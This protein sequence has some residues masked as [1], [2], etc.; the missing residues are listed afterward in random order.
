MSGILPVQV[1]LIFVIVCILFSY[2]LG[3]YFGML[4]EKELEKDREAVKKDQAK[5]QRKIR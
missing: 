2:S 4:L 1:M 5:P 3:F